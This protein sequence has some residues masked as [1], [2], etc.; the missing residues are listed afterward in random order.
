MFSAGR[1]GSDSERDIVDVPVIIDRGLNRPLHAQL[2]AQIRQ[3]ILD[4]LL[5]GGT[6][7]PSTRQL[8]ES[9]GIS[10]NVVL[11]A[12]DELCAEGSTETR[13]GS[14]TF[15]VGGLNAHQVRRPAPDHASPRWLPD[16]PM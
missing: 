10:R 12:Y 16:Y 11:A 5:P 9:L 13:H 3:H 1:S 15:V 2:S 4:G 8:A 6:R 7:L 14:G